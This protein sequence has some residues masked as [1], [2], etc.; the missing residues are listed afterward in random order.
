M[1][2][3]SVILNPSAKLRISSVKDLLWVFPIISNTKKAEFFVAALLIRMTF[4]H[5]I[6][7]GAEVRVLFE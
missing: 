1:S 7:R 6:R 5:S 3:D 4:R 2:P